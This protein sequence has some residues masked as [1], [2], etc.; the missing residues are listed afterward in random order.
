MQDLSILI[1]FLILIVSPFILYK[2][3]KEIIH[4]TKKN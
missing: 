3:I 2:C 1:V 4:E